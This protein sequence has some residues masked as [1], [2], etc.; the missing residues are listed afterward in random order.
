MRYH[1][2]QD[3]FAAV[4]DDGTEQLVTRGQPLPETHELVQRDLAASKSSP[5]RAPLFR[6]LDDGEPDPRPRR[7]LKG[8]S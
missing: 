1:Q 4:L 3:T 8:G 2:A 6:P 5:G 7:G